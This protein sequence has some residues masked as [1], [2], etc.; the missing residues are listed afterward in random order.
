MVM[1]TQPVHARK[2]YQRARRARTDAELDPRDIADVTVRGYRALTCAVILRAVEDSRGRSA[3]AC[4]A[5]AWLHG[6]VAAEWADLIDIN[7]DALKRRPLP[8]AKA[9]AIRAEVVL[10]ERK[11][12]LVGNERGQG[13]KRQ[14]DD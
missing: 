1:L 12:D 6:P 4:E 5:K 9:R 11:L 8:E 7:P 3:S 13:R 14:A 2:Q 10:S